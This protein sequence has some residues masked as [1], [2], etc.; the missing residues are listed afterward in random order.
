M[1]DGLIT[2]TP[3]EMGDVFGE[4]PVDF[5][6]GLLKGYRGPTLVREGKTFERG[7]HE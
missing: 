1:S 6:I 5:L 7:R 4:E 3:L 2:E